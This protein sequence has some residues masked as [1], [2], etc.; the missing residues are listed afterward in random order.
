MILIKCYFSC[1]SLL[2]I[3]LQTLCLRDLLKNIFNLCVWKCVCVCLSVC[4]SLYMSATF[5]CILIEARRW[6]VSV[7]GNCESPVV[8]AGNW[9][10]VLNKTTTVSLF[11]SPSAK[12]NCTLDQE[13]V[14][15]T[16]VQQAH[17]EEVHSEEQAHWEEVHSEEEEHYGRKCSYKSKHTLAF[18]SNL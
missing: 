4:L 8:G 13:D 5:V 12:Q 16:K 15:N 11:L 9:T 1:S 6:L 14:I 17:W 3:T 7:T 2:F 10:L 18:L